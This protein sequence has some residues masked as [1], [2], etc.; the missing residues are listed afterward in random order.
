MGGGGLHNRRGGGGGKSQV[1]FYPNEKGVG[2]GGSFSHTEEGS[3]KCFH[4]LKKKRG[5][6]AQTLLP[7]LETGEERGKK[8]RTPDFHLSI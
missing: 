6:G 7:C 3:A 8:F 1:K 5:G 4:P 2:G